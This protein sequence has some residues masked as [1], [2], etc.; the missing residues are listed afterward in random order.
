MHL[1]G[2]RVVEGAG[3]KNAPLRAWFDS[4]M[5]S[6]RIA[7]WKNLQDVRR[8]YPNADGVKLKSGLVVTVF[9][10]KG[11]EYRLLS[12]IDYTAQSVEVLEILTHAEYDKQA[13]KAR[14]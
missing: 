6:V 3:R 1:L 12:E 7:S 9:N 14:H 2:Q 13:W 10:V 8:V 11:N 4:W 5:Q